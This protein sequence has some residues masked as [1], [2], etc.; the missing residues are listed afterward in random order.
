MVH[1]QKRQLVVLAAQHKEERVH[2]LEQLGEVEP[3]DGLGD[4][5][6]GIKAFSAK[7]VGWC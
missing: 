1:M 3:P 7:N 4:L 2:E 5:K 6:A